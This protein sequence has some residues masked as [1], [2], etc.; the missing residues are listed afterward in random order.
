MSEQGYALK[1]FCEAVG[2]SRSTFYAL[3]HEGIAPR[4]T[5]VGKRMN[6]IRHEDFEA[7]MRNRAEKDGYTSV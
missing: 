6:L 7:W 3:K 5:R 2:I 4:V 1:D